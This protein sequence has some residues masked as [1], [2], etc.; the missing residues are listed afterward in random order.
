MSGPLRSGICEHG[1]VNGSQLA[2]D[3][4]NDTSKSGTIKLAIFYCYLSPPFLC[5]ARD[6]N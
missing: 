2:R 3:T 6:R 1:L 5:T 4:S